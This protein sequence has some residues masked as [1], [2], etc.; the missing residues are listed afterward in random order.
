MG[1]TYRDAGVD[2]D[3]GNELVDR[4]RPAIARTMRPEI[5]NDLGGFAAFSSIPKNY[6]DPVLVC[7]T[8]GAGTKVELA[9]AHD[10]HDTIGQDLVAMCV[11]DVLVYGAEPLL[12]LDY[13]ATGKLDVDVAERVVNG[14]ADGCALAGCALPG[15]ETAEMPGMY[16]P[17]KYDLAGFCVGVVERNRV[18]KGN[19]TA[20]GDALIGIASDGPHSNGFSLIRRLLQQAGTMAAPSDVVWKE[21]FAPTR[22]YVKAVLPIAEYATGMAH[23]TG[24]GLI[25]NPVRMLNDNLAIRLDLNEWQRHESFHWIKDVGNLEEFELLRTFNCGIG[26]VVA[27]RA[28]DADFVKAKLA[29]AGERPFEIGCIVDRGSAPDRRSVVIDRDGTRFG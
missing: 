12:F 25:E 19:T 3:A 28:S 5:L 7:A 6:Q 15:G 13:F 21:F 14:I 11:N 22:I 18:S 1:N 8:D 20:T 26:F 27:V 23:I 10:R 17:S 29:E 16:G 2:I 4:I 9:I 24:G